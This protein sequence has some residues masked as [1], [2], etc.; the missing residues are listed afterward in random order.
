MPLAHRLK[1]A[2]T[3]AGLT[4][5]QLAREAKL[6]KTYL[7]ELERDAKGRKKPSADVL[8]RIANALSTT[9]AELMGLATTGTRQATRA[10]VAVDGGWIFAG[11]LT[12]SHGRVI[13]DRAVHVVQWEWLDFPGMLANPKLPKVAVKPIQSTR[14]EIS[15]ASEIFRVPVAADWGL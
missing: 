7:W 1:D 8:L 10:V 5:D 14:I 4:L 15:A 3:K 11:D 13:L 6:S 2:R 9:I 12:E